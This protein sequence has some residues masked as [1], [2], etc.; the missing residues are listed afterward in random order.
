MRG[1]YHFSVSGRRSSHVVCCR[2]RN[3]I[4]LG[5]LP[6]IFSEISENISQVLWILNTLYFSAFWLFRSRLKY[7]DRTRALASGVIRLLLVLAVVD[8]IHLVSSF[9][10]FSLP[11][12]SLQFCRT[13]YHHI[14]P[15]TLP[16]AQVRSFWS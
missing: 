9:L 7:E 16:L 12:L 14:V 15:I 2:P 4:Q 10:T 1:D 6:P 8:S 3:H 11:R 5:V 13:T